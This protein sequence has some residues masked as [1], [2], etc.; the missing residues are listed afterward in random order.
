MQPAATGWAKVMR[1]A[2]RRAPAEEAVRLAWPI[3]CGAKVAART[4]PLVFVGGLLQVEVPDHAWRHQLQE[5][6]HRYLSEF[7]QLLGSGT[8]E[9]IEFVLPKQNR[10]TETP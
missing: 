1:E 3:I 4:R 10:V 7:A 9:C 2:L 5:L 6:E 8:V